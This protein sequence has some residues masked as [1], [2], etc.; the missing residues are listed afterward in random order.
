MP[1]TQ[2]LTPQDI[3]FIKTLDETQTLKIRL[4]IHKDMLK[5]ESKK[6]E[7]INELVNSDSDVKEINGIPLEVELEYI[8]NMITELEKECESCEKKLALIK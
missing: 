7:K 1:K 4:K 5:K 3:Q 6:L 2:K 8:V